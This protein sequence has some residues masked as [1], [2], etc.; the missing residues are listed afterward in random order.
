M[1][2]KIRLKY[3][4]KTQ[5]NGKKLKKIINKDPEKLYKALLNQEYIT[6]DS[7]AFKR[8][9][10]SISYCAKGIDLGEMFFRPD[11]SLAIHMTLVIRP[12]LNRR[13]IG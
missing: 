1:T 8:L 7:I 9:L 5:K 6:P 3:M 2:P 11:G 13:G 4:E 10:G 12:G